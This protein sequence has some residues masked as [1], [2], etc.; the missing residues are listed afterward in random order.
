MLPDVIRTLVGDMHIIQNLLYALC[1]SESIVLVYNGN[2]C[3]TKST[4]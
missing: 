2:L 4:K 1:I 3:W